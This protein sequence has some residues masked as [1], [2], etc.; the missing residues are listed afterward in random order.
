LQCT[1]L[2]DLAKRNEKT[3]VPVCT[4][5]FW[6]PV[7]VPKHPRR[8]THFVL[9]VVGFHRTGAE[10]SMDYLTVTVLAIVVPTLALYGVLM[11]I[12]FP[13]TWLRLRRRLFRRK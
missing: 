9:S 4:C 7:A 6:P 2:E 8:G 3:A 12:D 1:C 13:E 10:T 5:R 11:A